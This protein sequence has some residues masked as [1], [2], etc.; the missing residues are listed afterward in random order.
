MLHVDD[1]LIAG[2]SD[3]VK[4][5]KECLNKEFR[6]TDFGNVHDFIG[7][8]VERKKEGLFLNRS[9]YLLDV[10][11]KSGMEN[12]KPVKTPWELRKEA[13]SVSE[14]KDCVIGKK[15]YRRLLGCLIYAMHTT[16]PDISVAV[17]YY[18]QFQSNATKVHWIG[19][20]RIL[21]CIQGKLQFGLWYERKLETEPLVLVC[22]F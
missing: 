14:E 5:L 20:K 10:L 18:S 2:E 8:N 1:C 21:R 11:K 7:V 12:C 3:E 13:E 6:M 16:R 17:H 15:P 9:R 19:L 4:K 22:R